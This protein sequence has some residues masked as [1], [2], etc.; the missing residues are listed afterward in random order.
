MGGP[1]FSLHTNACLVLQCLQRQ[2]YFTQY[3]CSRL[4]TSLEPCGRFGSR[5]HFSEFAM[6][7]SNACLS[8]L[9]LLAPCSAATPLAKAL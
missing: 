3:H 9:C 5:F 2:L 1:R 6:S 7:Q 4:T 8:W